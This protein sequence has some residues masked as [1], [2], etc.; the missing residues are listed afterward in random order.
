MEILCGCVEVVVVVVVVVVVDVG[1]GVGVGV[2]VDGVVV[3]VV[4]VDGVV[5][6]DDGVV[7]VDDGVGVRVAVVKVDGGDDVDV[8]FVLVSLENLY[9]VL[10]VVH[11]P[12]H[13]PSPCFVDEKSGEKKKTHV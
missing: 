10:S 13:E 5:V 3:V 7:V 8:L 1:V 6:V 4:V 9:F 12:F 11:V 2:V